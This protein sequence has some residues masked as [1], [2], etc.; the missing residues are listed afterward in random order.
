MYFPASRGSVT[1]KPDRYTVGIGSRSHLLSLHTR[2]ASWAC[3]TRLLA[4]PLACR[5]PWGGQGADLQLPGAVDQGGG[6]PGYP[7]CSRLLRLQELA[8]P[9]RV[10]MMRTARVVLPISAGPRYRA[11]CPTGR[12]ARR[13]TAARGSPDGFTTPGCSRWRS[14]PLSSS[15]CL[16]ASPGS[17]SAGGTNHS[18][19]CDFAL[20]IHGPQPA[21]SAAALAV[22]ALRAI[23]EYGY[24]RKA[25]EARLKAGRMPLP[26]VRGESA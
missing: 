10:R 16:S 19:S 9:R 20:L 8:L 2:A 7:L 4:D 5:G 3:A 21:G 1:R 17:R 26:T 25:D 23:G 24:G 13:S 14:A 15:S 18:R 22:S 11:P 6:L 12:A